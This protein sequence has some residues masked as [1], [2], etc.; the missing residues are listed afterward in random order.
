MIEPERYEL[1]DDSTRSEWTRRDFFRLTGGGLIV[2][3]AAP[4]TAI[5]VTH[6]LFFGNWGFLFSAAFRTTLPV[7]PHG[8]GLSV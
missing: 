5:L 6:R 4:A 7:L 1:L 2:A 8:L 3:L